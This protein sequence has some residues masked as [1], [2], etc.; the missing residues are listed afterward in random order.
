MLALAQPHHQNE[1]DLERLT[2][3]A[4]ALDSLRGNSFLLLMVAP[5]LQPVLGMRALVAGAA[6]GVLV[7]VTGRWYARAVPRRLLDLALLLRAEG[8]ISMARLDQTLVLVNR[9]TSDGPRRA[10]DP[11]PVLLPARRSR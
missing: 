4:R 6:V 8:I 2:R 11:A 9:I 1:K 5:L 3:V 7:L 10:D